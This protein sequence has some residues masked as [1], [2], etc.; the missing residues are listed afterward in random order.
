MVIR[1]TLGVL[2]P[3]YV[4][5]ARVV[6]LGYRDANERHLAPPIASQQLA[7]WHGKFD[8][9]I[10]ELAPQPDVDAQFDV[11]ARESGSFLQPGPGVFVVNPDPDAEATVLTPGRDKGAPLQQGEYVCHDVDDLALP[12]LPDPLSL[13][14]LADDASRR[15]RARASSRWQAGAEW[16]SASRS[17]SGSRTAPARR[18]TTPTSGC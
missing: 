4:D 18:S 7:E 9:G 5:L 8:E 3:D 12:Y 11:A 17:G 13:G 15:P 14:R 10:G 2:P 6:P 1:S 16:S